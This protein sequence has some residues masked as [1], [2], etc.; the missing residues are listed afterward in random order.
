M[1]C[2]FNAQG[3]FRKKIEDRGISGELW[4]A[5]HHFEKAIALDPNFIDA[6]INMGNVLKEARIFDRWEKIHN[7]ISL[8]QIQFLSKNI[9]GIQNG[10]IIPVF[11]VN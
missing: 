9:G 8:E 7:Q 5:L 2:V 11:P 3:F 10:K 4:L 1:G 6:L